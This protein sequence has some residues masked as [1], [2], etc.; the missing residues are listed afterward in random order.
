L[1][2]YKVL[3]LIAVIVTISGWLFYLNRE[4]IQ[5]A[6]TKMSGLDATSVT[7]EKNNH[8]IVKN[9][10]SGNL[11]SIT[12]LTKGVKQGWEYLYYE[13]GNIQSKVR[14][15]KGL[16]EGR[17]EVY[18]TDGKLVRSENYLFGVPYGSW[19]HY[20]DDKL[21]GYNLY[22]VTGKV[23]FVMAYKDDGGLD[24]KKMD[25]Y[26][27][28]FDFYSITAKGRRSVVVTGRNA[29]PNPPNDINDLLITVAAPPRTK[30][31]VKL[32]INSKEISYKKKDPNTIVIQDFF[33]QSGKFDIKVESSLFDMNDKNINGINIEQTILLE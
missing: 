22:D 29:D 27:V 24:V 7:H 11:V 6:M 3:I 16:P 14:M 28:C 15:V 12:H 21:I 25:G 20:K 9:Y 33:K 10:R 13:N 19:Y 1:N 5:I 31:V 26:V 23:S 32:I 17:K 18:N 30:L 4:E 8:E 2:K